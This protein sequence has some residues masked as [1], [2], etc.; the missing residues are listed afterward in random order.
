M[1][2]LLM[3]GLTLISF[4]GAGQSMACNCKCKNCGNQETQAPKKS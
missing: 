1:K 3:I 4:L 2:K